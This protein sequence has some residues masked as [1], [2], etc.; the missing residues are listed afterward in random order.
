MPTLLEHAEALQKKFPSGR[1]YL[2][3]MAKVFWPDADWLDVKIGRANGGARKGARLAAGLAGRME[4]KGFVKL[5]LDA[6]Y[7]HPATSY[8]VVPSAIEA[9]RRA[10]EAK[11]GEQ[12]NG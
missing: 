4:R 7:E 2:T 12:A 3:A 5:D 6:N 1:I 8:R 9:A 11:Q 10:Q